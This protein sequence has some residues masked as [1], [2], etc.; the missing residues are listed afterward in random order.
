MPRQA[1]SP[2]PREEEEQRTAYTFKSGGRQDGMI[3]PDGGSLR[4]A[5]DTE[6]RA[7]VAR[8]VAYHK[9]AK[10][11]LDAIEN[12]DQ[13]DTTTNEN[14]EA[15]AKW[16]SPSGDHATSGVAR[17]KEKIRQDA[18]RQRPPVVKARKRMAGYARPDPTSPSNPSS[19]PVNLKTL[20]GKDEMEEMN[21]VTSLPPWQPCISGATYNE[22]HQKDL[23]NA[24]RDSETEIK[25]KTKQ[26]CVDECNTQKD[27][28]IGYAFVNVDL[29]DISSCFLLEKAKFPNGVD[30]RSDFSPWGEGSIYLKD[31]STASNPVKD[32]SKEKFPPNVV[33]QS[34]IGV[35]VDATRA[36]T[37][38]IDKISQRANAL[39][40]KEVIAM[41]ARFG[42]KN[43][44]ATSAR[45]RAETLANIKSQVQVYIRERTA[46]LEVKKN[47]GLGVTMERAKKKRIADSLK[48]RTAKERTSKAK[49]LADERAGKKT[50]ATAAAAKKQEERTQKASPEGILAATERDTKQ[51]EAKK[52]EDEKQVERQK[53]YDA[54]VADAHAKELKRLAALNKNIS[55]ALNASKTGNATRSQLEMLEREGIPYEDDLNLLQESNNYAETALK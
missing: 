27:A 38:E 48:E 19:E 52:L 43:A 3:I 53:E 15:L 14:E 9:I 22:H 28:C 18:V 31:M 36:T 2:T 23:K 8:S 40:A 34:D 50:K 6:A 41:N 45:T 35:K 12:G 30:P 21:P 44:N 20:T 10:S 24:L 39:M 26:Q 49:E 47:A 16:R 37:A 11:A 46:K 55:I 51:Q 29:G 42:G 17:L 54:Y 4:R 1:H 13:L 33:P 25:N 7:A 32:C 5:S